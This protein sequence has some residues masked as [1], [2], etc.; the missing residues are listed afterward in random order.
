MGGVVSEDVL[1]A[2]AY[3]SRVAEPSCIPVWDCV[4]RYGPVDAARMINQGRGADELLAA[5]AARREHAD[6]H[7]DLDAAHRHGIRLVVPE[8]DEWPHFAMAALER[9][10]LARA[11]RFSAGERIVAESGEPMPPLALWVKGVGQLACG[12]VRSVGIVG[13]RAATAYGEH[14][15]ADLGFGCASRDVTVVSGGAYG[16]DAAAHRSALAAGGQTVVVSAGGLDRPYPTGNAGLFTRAAETG[17][18]ISESP[19]GAAPQRHRFLTRNR[20]IAALSTGTVVV[21]AARRSG[22]A[23]TAAH[24]VTLGRPVMAVPG[25]VTSPMSAGCHDLLRRERSPALLVTC[26][27]DVLA[28]VGAMGDGITPDPPEPGGP[29]GTGGDRVRAELDGLD[30]VARR[31]F[32]GLPVRRPAGPDEIAQRCGVSP[33]EVI[34]SLPVLDLAGLLDASDAGY[35]IPSRLRSRR[36]KV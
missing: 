35:R 18:V 29:S 31:V 25:P 32:D 11:T 27:D 6:P 21:E 4:R 10:G 24:C 9:T 26:V 30:P 8:S 2:R 22:A 19:P 7:A 1:L 23:N 3:L 33:L 28:V 5:T 16:I 20:L 13:S 14:V 12:G 34:R 15:T 36:E 17:L